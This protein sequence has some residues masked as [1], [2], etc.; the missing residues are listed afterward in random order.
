MNFIKSISRREVYTMG[1]LV[2]RPLLIR[3]VVWH[4]AARFLG[5][6]EAID[7]LISNW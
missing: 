1:S 6:T 5:K 7:L 2:P 4:Y 3:Y